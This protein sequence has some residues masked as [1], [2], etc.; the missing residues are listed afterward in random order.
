MLIN[1]ILK[2]IKHISK[3][4]IIEEK[5]WQMNEYNEQINKNH[6]DKNLENV[7]AKLIRN[8]NAQLTKFTNKINQQ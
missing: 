6:P 4:K 5:T 2:S 3:T 7:M 8:Y 1:T